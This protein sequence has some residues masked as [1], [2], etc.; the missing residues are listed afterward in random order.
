MAPSKKDK[1][2][3]K[4]TPYG[5]TTST[6]QVNKSKRLVAMGGGD[7]ESPH[8]IEPDMVSV[9]SFVTLQNTVQQLVDTVKQ[10]SDAMASYTNVNMEQPRGVD[11]ISNVH[12]QTV[13]VDVTNSSNLNQVLNVDSSK[14]QS[15]G[16]DVL[17]LNDNSSEE[18][19]RLSV[20]SHL[21]SVMGD[22]MDTNEMGKE[23]KSV[24]L[25]VDLNVSDK[26]KQK[27]W[28]GDYVDF[29][30]LINTDDTTEYSLKIVSGN[31]GNQFNLA[32]VKQNKTI[33]TIGQWYNAYNVFMVV[34]CKKNP[35]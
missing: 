28:S 1:S 23:F 5:K 18:Q 14:N 20:E 34:Y 12:D 9:N 3:P 22:P 27:I 15:R 13:G 26:L 25:P 21:Q 11:L 4:V 8:L 35:Q 31:G 2:V 7:K 24:S 29:N 10:L 32:P 6:G 17:N 30:L 19:V 16:V 33:A